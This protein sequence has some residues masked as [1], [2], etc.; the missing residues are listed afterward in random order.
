[1]INGAGLSRQARLTARGLADL[2]EHAYYSAFASELKTSLPLAGY[3]GSARRYFRDVATKGKLRL[4]TGRLN[5]V[6]AIAGFAAT[7]DNRTWIVVI[8]HHHSS[9]DPT[10]GFSVHESIV[11]WL[12]SRP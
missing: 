12:Y 3:D 1:M 4:K 6:R 7:P 5:H 2:L 11:K 8:L 10:P 9:A